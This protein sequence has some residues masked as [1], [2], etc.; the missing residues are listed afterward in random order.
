MGGEAYDGPPKFEVDFAGKPLGEG[1]VAAAIDTAAT[2]RFADATDKTPYVQTFT[3]AVPDGSFD[4]QGKVSIKFL[5]EAYGGDGSDRDRNLYLASVTLNGRAVTASGLVSEAGGGIV[6]NMLVGEFLVIPDGSVTAVA[7][8]PEGGW[9]TGPAALPI[10]PAITGSTGDAP[11]AVVPAAA[12]QPVLRAALDGGSDGATCDEIYNV[13]GFNQ[14][15]NALTDRLTERLEQVIADLGS[16]RC[17][18]TVTG[19]ASHDGSLASN[20]LFSL[21]RAQNVLFYLERRGVV[22][23]SASALGAGATEAFG[24][25]FAANRR[26]VIAITP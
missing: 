15:S 22:F 12:P 24:D 10:D 1:T 14:N 6:D 4:A 7:P 17:H 11:V 3:F 20:A 23:L 13:V 26:V 21:E 8:A 18:V 9:P 16:R 25:G 19:Y 5:N 2:G